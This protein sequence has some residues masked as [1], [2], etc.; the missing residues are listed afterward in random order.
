[1]D[2]RS[3][4]TGMGNELHFLVVMGNSAAGAAEGE[5]GANDNGVSDFM[6]NTEG[7]VTGLCNIRRDGG[8]AD[9]LHGLLEEFPVLGTVNGLDVGT[10][11]V[12]AVIREEVLFLELHGDG[13]TG[14]SAE[15]G[16]QAVRFFLEDD[17]LYRLCRQGLQVDFI[18]QGLVG[19]DC[20][21]VGVDEDDIDPRL[22]Q[23]A[24]GLCAGVVEL[25]GLSDNDGSGAYDQDLLDI[26]IQRHSRYL[27]SW[28]QSGQT[29][30][31]CHGGPS[32]PP[33]GTV[34]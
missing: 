13:E 27:P 16:E 25:G 34:Q 15:A 11:E 22:L 17:S 4:E 10:D 9:F 23:N 5:R 29:G 7:V 28:I 8:L 31:P 18:C 6:G 21:G 12:D 14:L 30:I 26:L 3:L 32:W 20:C 33:G 19:H 1:M 2:G 24:A